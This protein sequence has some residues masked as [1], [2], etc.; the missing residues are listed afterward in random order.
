MLLVAAKTENISTA[1]ETTLYAPFAD[2]EPLLPLLDEIFYDIKHCDC[3]KHLQY[4]GV[5]NDLIQV[6]IKRLLSLRPDAMAR[7]PVIPGFNDSPDDITKMTA[8]LKELG[9]HRVQLMRYHNLAGTKYTPLG[10]KY[11]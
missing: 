3:E 1:I 2:I 6:N 8:Y 9:I 4:T 11:A 5:E 10:R 7:I